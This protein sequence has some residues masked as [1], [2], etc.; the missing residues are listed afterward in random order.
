[1]TGVLGLGSSNKRPLL[2]PPVYDWGSLSGTKQL[3][4]RPLLGPP[5][6]DWGSLSGTKQLKSLDM[7]RAPG[8]IPGYPC[9]GHG[10][11]LGLVPWWIRPQKC[12]EAN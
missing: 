11:I 4:K 8:N 1:M 12:S 3:N 7:S 6:Y 2:G 5:V 10:L 9:L